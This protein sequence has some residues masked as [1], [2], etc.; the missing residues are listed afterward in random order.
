[1]EEV[2]SPKTKKHLSKPRK[3]G[4]NGSTVFSNERGVQLWNSWRSH[5]REP[6]VDQKKSENVCVW[7][8]RETTMR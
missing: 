6:Y 8:N 2:V 5:E 1:M 7:R 4:W 3:T